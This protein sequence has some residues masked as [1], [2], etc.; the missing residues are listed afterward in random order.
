[1][2]AGAKTVLKNS[3]GRA[4]SEKA[5]AITSRHMMLALLERNEPDPAATLLAEL[6]VDRAALRQRLAEAR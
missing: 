3:L 6:P 4:A 5:R 1:M 2:T